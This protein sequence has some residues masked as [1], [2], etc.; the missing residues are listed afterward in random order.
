[1]KRNNRKMI[2]SKKKNFQNPQIRQMNQPK[3]F[4]KKIP[5]R[6]NYSSIFLSKVPNLSV[7]C[8]IYMIRIRFFRTAGIDL[9]EVSPSTM[10]RAEEP[11]AAEG[12]L[13]VNDAMPCLTREDLL[14]VRAF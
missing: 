5:S 14:K 4:R 10:N 12:Q 11:K 6:T 8:I 9:E 7:F 13:S 1:M 2:F 3:M